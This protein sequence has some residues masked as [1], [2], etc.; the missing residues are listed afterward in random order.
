MSEADG[1]FSEEAIEKRT[2]SQFQTFREKKLK[3]A[4]LWEQAEKPD[5]EDSA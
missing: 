3:E 2:Q 1:T 5:E 4:G